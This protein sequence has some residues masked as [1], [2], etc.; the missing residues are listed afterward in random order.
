[1]KENSGIRWGKKGTKEQL[2]HGLVEHDKYYRFYPK[3]NRKLLKDFRKVEIYNPTYI[4]SVSLYYVSRGI[5][6][7]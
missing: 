3:C 4:L 5:N 1:M 2:L 6:G 7:G